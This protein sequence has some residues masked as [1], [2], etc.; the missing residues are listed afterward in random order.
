MSDSAL[1]TLDIARDLE[2]TGMERAQAEAIARAIGRSGERLATKDD[3]QH[4]EAATKADFERFGAA[5]K[6]DFDRF[7]GTMKA[8]FGRFE[9]TAATKADLANLRADMYRALWIQGAGIVAIV[10]ALEFLP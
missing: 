4:L 9:A 3:L 5:T 6:A 8:D 10:T 1:G 7:E 2:A